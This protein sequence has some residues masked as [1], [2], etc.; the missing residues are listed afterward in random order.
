VVCAFERA[1]EASWFMEELKG[2]VAK[3][4]LELSAE[5]TRKIEFLRDGVDPIW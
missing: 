3:F 1:E 5:K 4:G 2:R